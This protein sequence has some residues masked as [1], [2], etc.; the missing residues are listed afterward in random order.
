MSKPRVPQVGE[1]V[2]GQGTLVAVED[3]TPVVETVLDYIFQSERYEVRII[4]NGYVLDTHH[5][6]NEGY[7]AEAIES[8]KRLSSKYG[9]GVE[10]QVV[11]ITERVRMRPQSFS[12]MYDP[13]FVDMKYSE[14]G[15]K[16]GMPK[17]REEVIWTSAG[18][19]D[20]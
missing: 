19:K 10:M 8:A 5:T 11:K 3:V 7:E 12:T 14:N 4:A 6:L 1:Y 16:R 2:R 20:E 9:S 15:A 18:D 13:E 17:D